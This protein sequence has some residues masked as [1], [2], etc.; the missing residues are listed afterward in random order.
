MA[1]N[2]R[3]ARVAFTMRFMHFGVPMKLDTPPKDDVQD[4]T[5]EA[6]RE[7]ERSP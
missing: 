3:T 4:V 5:D 7:A 6:L 1:T 2:G